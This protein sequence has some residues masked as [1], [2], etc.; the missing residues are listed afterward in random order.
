MKITFNIIVSIFILSLSQFTS[1]E[2]ILTKT[3]ENYLNTVK[4]GQPYIYEVIDKKFSAQEISIHS[5]LMRTKGAEW[6]FQNEQQNGMHFFRNKEKNQLLVHDGIK[7]RI[8]YSNGSVDPLTDED[9]ED[10]VAL[11]G[12]SDRF[13]F[14]LIGKDAASYKFVNKEYFISEVDPIGWTVF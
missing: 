2:T 6:N 11:K 7:S 5:E 4:N 9:L 13:L 12:K 1:G 8:I 10:T 3:V 14:E